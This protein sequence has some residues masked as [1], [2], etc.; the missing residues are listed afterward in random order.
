MADLERFVHA[1]VELQG[2]GEADDR[3]ACHS[4]GTEAP[5]VARASAPDRV[6]VP[7]PDRICA[8]AP[9]RT[10]APAPERGRLE[11]CISGA[12]KWL[13]DRQRE[14]GY[15][16][17]E[18][19]ADCTVESY[20]IILRAFM[21]KLQDPKIAKYAKTIR[22][23]M[24]P[25]GGWYNHVHGAPDLSVS[26]LSYFALKI[27]GVPADAPDMQRSRDVILRLG[28]ATKVNTYTKFQL[29]FFGQYDWGYVPA[30]P[31]E[32]MFLPSVAPMSIYALSSWARTIF[33]PLSII[34]ALKPVRPL[35]PHCSVDELF[36]GGRENA[37]LSLPRS[38]EVFSWKNFFLLTDKA[39]K[40]A[41]KFP[42][43]AARRI[44]IDKARKW[45][46]ERF[47]RSGGLGAILPAMVN[48]VTALKCLGYPDDH[49]LV[50]R[51]LRSLDGLDIEDTATETIRVQPCHSPVWDTA[52]SALALALDGAERQGPA[53]QK[54]RDWLL[55]KEVKAAGDWKLKNPSPPSGWYFEFENEFYPDV[56]DTIMVM[57]ALRQISPRG[58][59]ARVDEALERGLTWVLGMQS[60]DG[61]WASFDRDN[62]KAFLAKIP[63]A[64]F[65]AVIDPS[66]ADITSRVLEMFGLVFPERF[67]LSHP[68]VKRALKFIQKDQC[69]DGSWYGR[70]GVNYLYGTWQV[71]RG[72]R[73]IGED[74]T[75]PWVRRAV[76]WLR[77][78]QLPDGGWGERA[79][80]YEFPERKGKGPSTASQTAWALMGLLAAGEGDSNMVRRG[81]SYLLETHNSAGSWDEDEWT[82]TGF[83]RVFYMKYHYYCHY[84]P[85]LALVQYRRHLRGSRP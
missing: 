44:A 66:T 58:A 80:T 21:G 2:S 35:P 45:M 63:F 1:A 62:D 69:A 59:D 48:S 24:L 76:D 74:M 83:P 60:A 37:D 55:S 17:A 43:Y 11:E 65:N 16:V 50:I 27:A 54:A 7:A 61:G 49:P 75:A 53:L 39:L 29:A 84:W 73:L 26:V 57:M 70:W 10:C 52:I 67:G 34:Y 31:P 30:V 78:V 81:L 19:E 4:L 40:I 12:G 36:V 23:T 22:E 3:G 6:R 13:L 77:S 85:L 28:G 82:G 47:R 8:P 79:D 46:L 64:D 20:A 68:V 25:G 9:D 32:I 72:L 14:Q 18:F 38:T 41:E 33:V 51:C 56:D 5:D 42:I 71:L 15:W